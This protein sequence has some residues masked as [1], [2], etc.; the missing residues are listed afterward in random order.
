MTQTSDPGTVTFIESWGSDERIIEAAR[1]STGKGFLGWGPFPCTD[2]ASTG[3]LMSERRLGIVNPC[4]KCKG[5]GELPGDEK[6]LRYLW[7]HK[8]TTPFEMAGA[9]YEVSAPIMTFRQWFTHRTQSRNEHSARYGPLPEL[10]YLPTVERCL[11]DGGRNKQAQPATT[12]EAADAL[13]RRVTVQA[14]LG[15][16]DQLYRDAQRC[17]DYALEGGIPKELA[18]L[19]LTVGRFSKMRV[20]ANLLNWTKFLALRDDDH[21]QWE[22]H[23]VAHQITVDLSARFP[24]TMQLFEEGRRAK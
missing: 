1:M 4:P 24:R 3:R 11:T 5:R 21:A 8:H 2:C 17:Y 7:E 19:S 14:W 10:D 16:L 18:R 22:I 20:S 9:V 12:T 23:Q 13:H 15:M 6:L